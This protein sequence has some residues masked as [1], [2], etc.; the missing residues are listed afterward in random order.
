MQAGGT[1][2]APAPA[3]DGVV[4]P[5]AIVAAPDRDPEDRKADERRAPAELLGFCE[6]APGMKVAD[7]G[8]GGGY[9]TELLAR[10]VGPSGAVYGHNTKFIIERFADEA[11]RARLAKPVNAN[12]VSVIR[13]FDDPLPPEVAGQLDRVVNVL[14]Y[15]D[16]E[17]QGVDRAAHN[18]SILRALKPGGYYVIVDASA[19]EGD[20]ASQSKTLHRVEESLVRAE[21]QAAG[22]ELVEEAGFLRNP[23]DARDWNALP[24]SGAGDGQ[25]SDKF[26]LK[27]KK[28]A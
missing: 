16:F 24:W 18:A 17:W 8:A 1:E 22:F 9:T 27:F 7:I 19:R 2:P 11:W 28:P 26:V 14:F 5:A 23:N 15:H 13:E 10:A 20:G 3:A 6:L 12:V 25:Y 4:D 21:L